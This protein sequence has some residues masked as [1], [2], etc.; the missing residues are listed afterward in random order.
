MKAI[1]ESHPTGA[2]PQILI[3]LSRSSNAKPTVE[4]FLLQP[5]RNTVEAELV[6]TR[7]LYTLSDFGFCL[8]ASEVTSDDGVIGIPFSF[9][10]F[11]DEDMR[12]IFHR[13]KL[14]RKLRFIE[15]LYN[16]R[17]TLPENITPEHVRRIETLFRGITE[18]EFV[19]R[20]KA[21]TVLVKAADI[22]VSEPP[23]TGVG[24]YTQLLGSEEAVLDHPQLFDVGPVSVSLKRAVVANQIVLAPLR[25]GQDQV[26]RFEV[27]D[28]LITYRYQRYMSRDSRKRARRR[29]DQFYSQ[30]EREEPAEMAATL[31]E[32][33]MSDVM[34]A[35][36][37]EIAVGWLEYHNIPD[38]F[39]PQEPVLD[40][41]RACWR[42]PV[43]LV[44]ASGKGAPVGELLIDLKTGSIVEEPSSEVMYQEGLALA[45]SILR[46]G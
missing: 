30:L 19:S 34:P 14:A 1:I 27:L 38:R 24:S 20:G 44:Y 43:H 16:V 5:S 28:N 3:V 6:Y 2:W 22:N 45:E 41:E 32:L 4:K 40:G 10:T 9:Q 37:V 23:F 18:G 42:V 35:E 33:L 15:S 39:S 11:D 36:A 13:A 46:V 7:V 29:L 12:G 25:A 31:T 17:F 21:I 26:V 8:L